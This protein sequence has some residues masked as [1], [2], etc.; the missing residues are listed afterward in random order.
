[1][2][3]PFPDISSAKRVGLDIETCDPDLKTKGPGVRRP[4]SFIAGISVATDDASWYFPMRHEGGENHDPDQVLAWARDN[5][6]TEG[7][8][9][10]G[11][12]LLYDLDFLAAEGVKV[13]GP[14]LDVQSAE[15]LLDENRFSYS[16][17]ELASKY[18]NEHKK[19][20]M[21]EKYVM[22]TYGV[23]DRKDVA[24]YIWRV[25]GTMAAEY[26][27]ADASLPLRIL[28]AQELLLEKEGLDYIWDIETRLVPMLLA[29]RQR[30][31]RVDLERAEQ[32]RDILSERERHALDRLG[33]I[34]PSAPTQV[35]KIFDAEGIEYPRTPTGKPSF[36]KAWLAT[37]NHPMAQAILDARAA[38]K[39]RTT[40]IEGAILDKHIN[41]RVHTLFHQLRGDENGAVSGRFSSSLPNL[42]NI[43][44]RG[45]MAALIRGLF[46]PEEGEMWWRHDYSQVE[47][48]ILVAQMERDS[49]PVKMY[50][51]TPDLDYHQMVSDMTGIDR[52]PA[53][54]INFGLVYGMGVKTLAAN[55]GLDMDAA[56]ALF[57][58]YHARV[59]FVKQLFDRTEATAR[60][61]GYVKTMFGRRRRFPWLWE[62]KPVW[63]VPPGRFAKR[64]YTHKAL[65]A[66]LQGT[67][68]DI[69]K[70]A[71]VEIWESGVCDEVGCPLLTV[72]DELDWSALADARAEMDKV[73]DI[74]SN[75]VTLNVPLLVEEETGPNWGAL[76]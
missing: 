60:K 65:N 71:M 48:R 38:S 40:F 57:D 64:G 12:N 62:G 20:A 66:V 30:G 39:L 27:E 67:A 7:V 43:P 76:Q 56:R 41:G 29:M 24:G 23:K 8:P 47:Y 32:V 22:R 33:G 18:L 55:L 58:Q 51:D 26:A 52:K 61:E 42:Q 74:M 63:K 13:A 31:V 25:P 45:D 5:L 34:N 36:T 72:H 11:A 17:D 59:P 3:T 46:L 9:K 21:L 73:R 69:M 15:P 53:K 37:V 2:N 75:C 4:G 14:F 54:N 49:L 19:T 70:I 68:A 50:W 44:S 35:A 6:C 28:D 16:L 10:V 1:M